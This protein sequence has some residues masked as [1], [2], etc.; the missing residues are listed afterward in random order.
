MFRSIPDRKHSEAISPRLRTSAYRQRGC[1]LERLWPAVWRTEL[2][3]IPTIASMDRD[4]INRSTIS[5][6]GVDASMAESTRMS[7]ARSD[8]R[9]R[10]TD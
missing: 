10:R 8:R 3:C 9:F 2:M 1:G 4:S 5:S 7:R 6:T